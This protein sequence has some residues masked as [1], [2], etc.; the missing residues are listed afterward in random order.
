MKAKKKP[1]E[2]LTAG[3]L[4]VDLTPVLETVE[5][6]EPRKRVGGGKVD[7]RMFTDALCTLTDGV[8][9]ECGRAGGQVEGSGRLLISQT[10]CVAE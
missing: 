5:V 7:Q 3:D 9:L 1:I 2:K 10:S 6:R 8:G 4:G